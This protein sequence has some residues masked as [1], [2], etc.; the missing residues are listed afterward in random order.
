M[1]LSKSPAGFV[2][3]L[4]RDRDHYQLPLALHEAGLLTAMVTDFYAPDEPPSWLP[5]PLRARYARGLPAATSRMAKMSFSL[6]SA[7]QLAKLPMHRIF[8]FTDKLLARKAA[9]VAGREGAHLYCYSP[10]LPPE[11]LIAKGTRRAIFEFHPL[12]ELLWELLSDDHALYPQTSWSYEME[13]ATL[14]H[15]DSH[16]AWKRADAVVCASAI[17][18]RS[19]EYAGCE[20]GKITVIPY[21]FDLPPGFAALEHG[22]IER[23]SERC[24]FL[25]VGQGIQ[26]KG[27]HHLIRAWQ[28]A[29]LEDARLTLV[30]YRIDPGIRAMIKSPSIRLLEHQS[31]PALNLLYRA[32]DIFVMPSL[33]EGFGLVYLEALAR[34]CHVVGTAN[35]GL[36]N[37]NLPADAATILPTGNIEALVGA[38]A[39]SR[40]AWRAGTFDREAIMAASRQWRWEDFRRAVADHARQL[41]SPGAD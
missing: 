16:N 25:F 39:D 10:Y 37:L 2:C 5:N 35:T 19:L 8:P 41:L 14:E 18:K 29:D 12:P 31:D 32:A 13:R 20:A 28:E 6:Q 34:G 1:A 4:N 3:A 22:A 23:V 33:V 11:H 24:E 17:T 38:L 40:D 9:K 26:R 21:G 15:A 27:L 7:A 30:C 36:P